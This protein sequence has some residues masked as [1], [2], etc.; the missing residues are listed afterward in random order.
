VYHGESPLFAVAV[1]RKLATA[2]ALSWHLP[3]PKNTAAI[4]RRI[5]AVTDS[6]L[7]QKDFAEHPLLDAKR[8]KA[9]GQ[10]GSRISESGYRTRAF[11]GTTHHAEVDSRPLT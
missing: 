4:D 8:R 1:C 3:P 11:A 6:A 7:T 2:A 9:S 10:A 5:G